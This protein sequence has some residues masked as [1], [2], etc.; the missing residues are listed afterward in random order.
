MTQQL[1]HA[2]RPNIGLPFVVAALGSPAAARI[3]TSKK[4]QEIKAM[5]C[6]DAV[7]VV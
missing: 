4:N 5:Q 2:T 1:G 6:Q 7:V 3:R